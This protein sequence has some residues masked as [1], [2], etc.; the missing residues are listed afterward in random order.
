MLCAI[1]RESGTLAF[2]LSSFGDADS[3]FEPSQHSL[4]YSP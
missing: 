3:Y 2:Q 1:S 4:R